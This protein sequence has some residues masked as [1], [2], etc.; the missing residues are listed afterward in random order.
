MSLTTLKSLYKTKAMPPP[1]V[2]SLVYSSQLD[3]VHPYAHGHGAK[4][5]VTGQWL[6]A[7]MA[8]QRYWDIA[9]IVESNDEQG[10]TLYDRT[11]VFNT[12]TKGNTCTHEDLRDL[13]T[14]E[15]AELVQEV[16]DA[17][18]APKHVYW[19]A[20]PNAPYIEDEVAIKFIKE[21]CAL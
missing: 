3:K 12:R 19:I 11:D 17:G 7:N 21:V 2:V 13:L 15:H 10:H 16:R 1:L 5:P 8:G 9:L 20:T 14:T 6:L 4:F 18:K